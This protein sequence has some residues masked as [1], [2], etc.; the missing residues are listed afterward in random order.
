MKAYLWMLSFV[1]VTLGGVHAQDNAGDAKLKA[2]EKAKESHQKMLMPSSKLIGL[3]VKD[4]DGE[5]CG[6]IN[7]F[8]LDRE[9]KIHYVLIGLGGL[10]GVGE[11]EIAV[12]WTAF[13][14]ICTME[15]EKLICNPKVRLTSKQLKTAPQLKA[16]S[17]L[18]LTDADWSAKNA[19][20]FQASKPVSPIAK[21]NLIIS[22]KIIDG[23]VHGSEKE[24][25]GQLDEL[26]I[27]NGT[28]DVEFLVL[29]RGGVA[30]IG[31]SYV[32]VAFPMLQILGEGKDI[33][34]QYRG[35]V[36]SLE[37]ATKVTPSEYPELR[38]RSVAENTKR[39]ESR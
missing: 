29:G 19:T 37:N 39:G 18:E 5:N 27:R 36:A 34:L 4:G 2:D 28:G 8:A 9:G 10:A 20:F 23:K 30:G 12:P 3:S 26:M 16:Q 15:G 32:A 33:S 25:V 13:Q 7:A 14:C 24:T 1:V 21:N 38:L 31:E 6:N 22:S 11:T 17:Y 35:N